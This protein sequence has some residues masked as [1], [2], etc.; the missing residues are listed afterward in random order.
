M[1]LETSV[2]T[3]YLVFISIGESLFQ[4]FSVD[5]GDIYLSSHIDT[6]NSN[7]AMIT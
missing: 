4:A 2:W 3:L 5:R 1:Y 6:F 7:L